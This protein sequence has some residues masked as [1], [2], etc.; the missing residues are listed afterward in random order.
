ML[1]LK[2]LHTAA[3]FAPL[4]VLQRLHSR[5]V[6]DESPPDLQ[7]ESAQT[8]KRDA[9]EFIQTCRKYH[10]RRSDTLFPLA[11]LELLAD[12]PS[13]AVAQNIVNA[14]LECVRGRRID[15]AKYD[16]RRCS[17]IVVLG[18]NGTRR[19]RQAFKQNVKLSIERE[20]GFPLESDEQANAKELREH[21]MLL[22]SFL[23]ELK[24]TC[25]ERSL[26]AM[27]RKYLHIIA[28]GNSPTN[29]LDQESRLTA[30]IAW[31]LAHEFN[32]GA[33][34]DDVEKYLE[35][36]FS[37]TAA[38]ILV[39]RGDI[40]GI[41]D[42]IFNIVSSR[43]ARQL[44]S[45]S[46]LV[47]LVGQTAIELIVKQLD[48]PRTCIL[49]DGG[50]NFTLFV[51]AS[52]AQELCECRKK[53]ERAVTDT[54][55]YLALGWVPA[56]LKE[57]RDDLPSVMTKVAK[58]CQA[59]KSRKFKS[60]DWADVFKPLK[61]E[62]RRGAFAKLAKTLPAW[63]LYA[64]THSISNKNSKRKVQDWER[65]V[66]RLEHHVDYKKP[67]ID[68]TILFNSTEYAK[69]AS[70]FR[71][72][73]KDVPVWEEE[74]LE[75]YKQRWD[76]DIESGKMDKGDLKVGHPIEFAHLGNFAL[77]NSGRDEIAVLKLDV[78]NLGLLFRDGLGE[79]P[80]LADYIGLSEQLQ[81]FFEG[82]LNRLMK[83]KKFDNRIYMVFSGGDD[84]FL[85][86]PWDTVFEFA[87]C[88]HDEFKQFCGGNRDVTLSA[89]I[90]MI[91]AKFSVSRFS[92]LAEEALEHAKSRKDKEGN[93]I[94]DAV[95]VLGET[96]SWDCY[97]YAAEIR[98]KLVHLINDH[99]A[100]RDILFK[101]RR[102]CHDL[103]HYLDKSNHTEVP[104]VYR[105][106]WFLSDLLDRNP[107]TK[108]AEEKN[109]I[110][111]KLIEKFEE[112]FLR[113]IAGHSTV[114]PMLF[115]VAARWAEFSLQKGE[116]ISEPEHLT[117][118]D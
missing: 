80:G 63:E 17:P 23:A 24:D 29:S 60:L 38:P 91:P 76:A 33:L 64:L 98:D 42:F 4:G 37:S 73:V 51:P 96:L 35:Q 90:I 40:S 27:M 92:P 3:L 47:Q 5:D 103:K 58:E 8:A 20:A 86:G 46:F 61:Q 15:D 44:K 59:V 113:S 83:W 67:L 116:K 6:A 106:A 55:L 105:L 50:G 95:H 13:S 66:D 108:Q 16:I 39:V 43:A 78:D 114:N 69:R 54:G 2:H 88:L 48:I 57:L 115:A 68:E 79:H 94:K 7:S 32:S 10:N 71:F 9:A 101:V 31:C 11:A 93:T 107:Q 25:N 102:L 62:D 84:V 109:A 28:S 41:Q 49:L 118:E 117:L 65:Y 1:N 111:T 18:K 53:L 72:M 81:W 97:N 87:R 99:G 52:R 34:G 100:G 89:G 77:E 14:S 110:V 85:L 30:A 74:A 56:S 112:I 22:D 70:D 36:P 75:K 26:L 82:Y 104:P 21:K 19:R 45:R 12:R